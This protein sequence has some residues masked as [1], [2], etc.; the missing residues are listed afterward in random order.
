LYIVFRFNEFIKIINMIRKLFFSFVCSLCYLFVVSQNSNAIY[1][2]QSKFITGDD[3]RWSDPNF[4]DGK[5]ADIKTGIVWQEQGY[6]DYHGFAWYRM[7]VVIPSSLKDKSNWKDSLRIFLAHVNDVDDTYLNGVKIGH[8]G[9]FPSESGGYV[10]KWQA[11]RSY[12]LSISNPAIKWDQE[13]IIAVRV[14]DGSGTGGIFMG[15]PYIDMLEKINGVDLKLNGNAINY[16]DGRKMDIPVLIENK[17]NTEVPIVF[18]YQSYDFSIKKQ[19]MKEEKQVMLK[20]FEK[21]KLNIV[22]PNKEGIELSYSITDESSKL[23]IEKQLPVPYILSPLK[24]DKIKINSPE[25]IGI[26]SNKP[27]IYRI[28]VSGKRPIKY[29]VKNL[30]I[31]LELNAAEGIISG[32]A[33]VKDGDYDVVV[34]ASNSKESVAKTIHLKIGSKTSLTPPM[35]WNSWNCWGLSVSDE[36]VRSSAQAMIDKGL[37]DYGWSYINIDDGWEAP[38]RADNGEILCNEK[39]PDM[40]KLGDWLHSQGL[41]FGIYTSPGD[42]TCGGYLGSYKHELQDATSY[43]SWGVDYL[44][45]DWCSYYDIVSYDDT[46]VENFIQPYRVMQSALEKQNR[47]IYYSLCQYGMKHVEQWGAS[48]NAQSWRTTGDITDTWESLSEIGFSQA[49]FYKYAEPGRWNDPDMLIVGMVGWGDNLHPTRLTPHEQYTHI[50]LWS[51]LSSPLLIGCDISKLDPFTLSILTNDEVIAINQDRLGKQAQQ[52]VK[53][54]NY[55]VWIKELADGSKAVGVFNLTNAYQAINLK[56]KDFGLGA[57]VNARDIW[58]QE[59]LGII[60]NEFSELIPAHG[61]RL[62]KI[63]ELK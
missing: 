39:F 14:Y 46:I 42:K 16:L 55:Q 56:W 23:K 27:F 30:P 3:A 62:Y 13:N 21:Y 12:Q 18:S 26:K 1:L 63:K 11:E 45:H 4:D 2:S 41:K 25:V 40:K 61:G 17:F 37:V 6:Q 57:N 28:P 7:H 8:I 5:W 32:T 47:D 50:S 38:K 10:S 36:K 35:G 9:R 52:I 58:K 60:K 33:K 59:D 31:G 49:P 48:V 43:A 24:S 53:T 22:I 44:K 20:P 19:L 29:S 34:N 54:D 15:N 51:L